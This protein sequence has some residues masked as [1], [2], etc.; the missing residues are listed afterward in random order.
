MEALPSGIS[1]IGGGAERALEIE[2]A[3][4]RCCAAA[5]AGR[6]PVRAIA[7]GIANRADTNP[8]NIA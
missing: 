8:R 7:I 6:R 1:D 4:G 2:A 5:I 3:N